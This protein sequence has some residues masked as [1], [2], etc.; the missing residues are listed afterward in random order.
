MHTV[1][2]NKIQV[3]PATR[4]ELETKSKEMVI[5]I[6]T[7]RNSQTGAIIFASNKVGSTLP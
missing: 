1:I 4:N 3:D 5:C 6:V 2:K 7:L